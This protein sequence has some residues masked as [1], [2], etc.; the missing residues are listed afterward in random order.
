MRMNTL[1]KNVKRLLT[2]DKRL[3]HKSAAFHKLSVPRA[4]KVICYLLESVDKNKKELYE[5]CIATNY[6]GMAC[7]DEY[8]SDMCKTLTNNQECQT[9]DLLLH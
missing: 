6:L 3:T 7:F 9:K 1:M 8:S 2:R 4:K 5:C